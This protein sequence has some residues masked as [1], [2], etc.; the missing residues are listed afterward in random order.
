MSEPKCIH[1]TAEMARQC[2]T[3]N[4]Y[5]YTHLGPAVHGSKL[6]DYLISEASMFEAGI[7]P[8]TKSKEQAWNDT[9]MAAKKRAIR[10]AL[11]RET[12][13]MRLDHICRILGIDV[14]Q[15]EKGSTEI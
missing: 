4:P 12:M 11:R 8:V 2:I 1:M 15:V 5:P 13:H 14:A 9:T 3:C 7:L 6:E 10:H